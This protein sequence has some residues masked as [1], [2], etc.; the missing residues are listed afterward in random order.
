[1][2]LTDAQKIVAKDKS[3][4]RVL[5]AGRRFGKSYLSIN[6]MAK[7]A[8]MPDKKVMY[9]APTYRQAKNA[10]WDDLKGKLLELRWVKKINETDL[11]IRLINGS[12]I[13]LRGAEN[14][15][16]LRGIGLDFVVFDE[17][18]SIKK[19]AW[20]EVIRPA[21]SAEKT[22]GS[23]LFIG[24]PKGSVN[25]SKDLY[26]RGQTENDSWKSWQMTTMDGG[27]VTQE[28]FEA[29]KEDSDLRTFRQ[30]FMA[31]FESYNNAIYHN[32]NDKAIVDDVPKIDNKTILYIGMDFNVSPMACVIG[33]A[34]NNMMYIVDSIEIYGSNTQE[35]CDEINDR[36][37]NNTKIVY[38]DATGKREYTSSFGNSDHNIIRQ[39]GMTIKVNKG[40]PKVKDRI[41]SV[42]T[43]FSNAKGECRLKIHRKNKS[44]INC[45][46]KQAYKPDTQQ[47]DKDSGLDH[48]PDALGYLIHTLM[49]VK[50]PDFLSH[51]NEAF[52]LF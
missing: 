4:F 2:P 34:H 7:F 27:H 31:T 51:K 1:M 17:F 25:W 37:P 19:E 47:P 16:S 52:G 35:M 13:M 44:L 50:R 32:F 28:E 43:A 26:D 41:T 3:R 14:Y 30:E 6:E 11:S 46:Y 12:I 40:N 21:I 49:P 29:A 18:A 22:L 24:T 5:I 23:V 8:R 38:P 36:Y 15:D 9:I 33:V 39:N 45:L 10:I 48:L 20:T 42:N